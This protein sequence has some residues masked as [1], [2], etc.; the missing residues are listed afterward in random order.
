M[1]RTLW[2]FGDSFTDSFLP[3]PNSAIHWRQKYINWK[4]YV[5]KVFGE[6]IADRLGIELVNKGVGGCD[7]N[8]ILEEFSK[9]CHLIKED[10]IVIVGWTNPQRVRFATKTNSWGF[11]NAQI[12]N[13]N[14]FFAHKPLES[15]NL[16]SETTVQEV[17]INKESSLYVDE[18]YNWGNLINT[19]T[20]GAKT[21][22][23]SW[24]ESFNKVGIL[25]ITGYQAIRKETNGEVDD[26]HWNESSH[27]KLADYF[28]QLI[29]TGN[30]TK[31]L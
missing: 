14:G 27:Y 12:L 13:D 30:K 18:V 5:P 29:S 20:K 8:D 16:I 15:F 3:A 31:L 9:V 22:Q 28:M 19:A 24:H 21:I 4:G 23:W 7:N 25:Y 26:G 11:F 2:T 17:L 1:K 6:V 10:D